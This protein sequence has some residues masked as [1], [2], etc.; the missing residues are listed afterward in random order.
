MLEIETDKAQMDVEAQ[1]DGVMAK[2]LVRDGTQKVLVGQVIAITAEDG[3]DISS[4]DLE[5]NE[6]KM[7]PV[8][9][10][11]LKSM[12]GGPSKPKSDSTMDQANISTDQVRKDIHLPAV[13]RLLYDHQ[14]EDPRVITPTGP[15]GRLLKGDVLAYVGAIDKEIPMNLKRIVEKKQTLDL[16]N[17]VLQRPADSQGTPTSTVTPTPP[18]KPRLAM[19][20]TIVH[21]RP[22]IGLQAKAPGNISSASVES[23]KSRKRR[24]L[25]EIA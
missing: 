13:L 11:S 10:V 14:I 16:S 23:R 22:S 3:D 6:E 24:R 19:V 9:R 12:E 15:H 1:D 2:V 5:V 8:S 21:L 7:G 20:E 25:R 4:L 18:A 17:I